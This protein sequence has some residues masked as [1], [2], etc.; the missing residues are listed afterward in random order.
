MENNEKRQENDFL[1]KVKET[2]GSIRNHLNPEYR[3]QYNGRRLISCIMLYLFLDVVR[4]TPN[5]YHI[6]PM[7]VMPLIWSIVAWIFLHYSFWSYKG[8]VVDTFT[9]NLIHFG[10]IW[11]IIGRIVMQNCIVLVWI[12]LIAPF[13]GIKTWRKA[14]KYDKDLTV[15]NAKAEIWE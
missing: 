14:V 10:S 6:K 4:Y 8:G 3:K 12:A 7:V 9:S 1:K 11:T 13:S 2:Y 5:I 15:S